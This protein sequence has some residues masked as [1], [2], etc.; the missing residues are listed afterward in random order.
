MFRHVL[1][2]VAVAVLPILLTAQKRTREEFSLPVTSPTSGEQMYRAYCADC[3]G[4]DAR[5]NGSLAPILKITPPN[6]TTLSKRNH[7]K[8][9]YSLV[10]QTINGK[11]GKSSH[12]SREMPIWGPVFRNMGK[13]KKGEAELRMKTLTKYIESLQAH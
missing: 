8:F 9:P 11:S 5:G 6:L 2:I 4:R 3:H 1:L 13:G 7:N 12:G 10:Y